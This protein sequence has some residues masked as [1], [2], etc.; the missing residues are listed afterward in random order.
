MPEKCAKFDACKY[1][2]R[3]A[4]IC[5]EEPWNCPLNKIARRSVG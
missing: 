1:R 4:V 3:D 5:N 2:D